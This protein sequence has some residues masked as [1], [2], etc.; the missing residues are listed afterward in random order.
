MDI[1]DKKYDIRLAS[2]E[3]IDD[4]MAFI[5]DNMNRNHILGNNRDFFE[6]E[7]V[8]G[9]KVN[10][11]I[12]RQL[13][14][15]Q[16]KGI[17]GFLYASYSQPKND[18]WT[19]M[20]MASENSVPMLGIRLFDLVRNL[21]DVRN[22]LGVGDDKNTTVPIMKLYYKYFTGKLT[23][24]YML[25]KSLTFNIAN[26]SYIPEKS[27]LSDNSTSV[28]EISRDK[29]RDCFDFTA[30][31]HL[32]PYKDAGFFEHRYFDHPIYKYIIYGLEDTKNTARKAL[33]VVREQK[34]DKSIALRIIDYYG[35]ECLLNGMNG[36][37]EKQ[38]EKYEY[39]D[40][41]SLGFD[42]KIVSSAG[43]TAVKD[44][45]TNIV[46]DYFNPFVSENIDI[47]CTGSC[48]DAHFCKGDADQDRPS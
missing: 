27:Q 39:I 18:I 7:H 19:V 31:T 42:D 32:V 17:I 14:D 12:A 30:Y 44:N 33:M 26:I 28:W 25:S 3:D 8:R 34:K 2:I 6:Y 10:F 13:S 46:P 9:D 35:D 38:L 40:F 20:W 29:L 21:P 37:W 4:I 11:A 41:Y 5:C 23:H 16:I 36:F 24:Y 43:F 1:F 47:Y 22:V 45:D 48:Y 15:R